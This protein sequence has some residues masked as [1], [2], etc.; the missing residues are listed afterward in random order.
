M[1][2]KRGAGLMRVIFA[3]LLAL[4][5]TGAGAQQFPDAS[6]QAIPEKEMAAMKEAA[7][8]AFSDPE[9][10]QFRQLQFKATK[11]QKNIMG[12]T[13]QT[14]IIC[15]LVNE[16]NAAGGYVG[17]KPFSYHTADQAFSRGFSC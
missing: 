6:D 14:D 11:G 7:I 5:A 12:E 16:K 3:I 9:A 17:Y 13:I 4:I 8:L 1:K 15:G 10:T 2:S